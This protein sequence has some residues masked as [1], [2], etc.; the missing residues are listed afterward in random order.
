MLP[1]V[2]PRAQGTGSR[3]PGASRCKPGASTAGCSKDCK[4]VR[5]SRD[6]VCCSCLA[7]RAT[8]G[9]VSNGACGGR[10]AA[11]HSCAPAEQVELA[12]PGHSILRSRA[13]LEALMHKPR[14]TRRGWHAHVQGSQ[15]LLSHA[16][17]WRHQLRPRCEAL[18]GHQASSRAGAPTAAGSAHRG[19][20]RPG[21]TPST[22]TL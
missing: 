7:R 15:P 9:G 2:P 6:M 10:P 5:Q 20:G 19:A 18:H 22:M 4:A 12:N 11:V 1:G 21:R 3:D 14:R 16:S 13:C 8:G 17:A